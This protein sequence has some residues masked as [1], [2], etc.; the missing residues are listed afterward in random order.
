[1]VLLPSATATSCAS[2][3]SATLP[4][5]ITIIL[6]AFAN[7]RRIRRAT[8]PEP[9]MRWAYYHGAMLESALLAYVI[10]AMF[11]SLPYFELSYLLI[12]LTVCLRRIVE[13]PPG[14]PAEGS[15]SPERRSMHAGAA[16][17]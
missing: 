5:Q 4:P 14:Q 8:W 10:G 9:K 1:M 13:Q 17:P 3:A 2:S 11:V 12:A 16:A 6:L 7:L 15:S